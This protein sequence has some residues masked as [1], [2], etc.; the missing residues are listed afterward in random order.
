M[1]LLDECIRLKVRLVDYEKIEENGERKVAFGNWAGVAGAINAL[2]MMGKRMLS[3][4]HNTPLTTVNDAGGY[5]TS[6][7]AAVAIQRAGDEVRRGA[8]AKTMDPLTFVITGSGR[9]SQGAQ[10][11][12][13]V[14]VC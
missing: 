3:L 8:L 12:L 13:N 10:Q 14:M 1:A 11:I 6:A 2:H 5:F 7:E 4:G 9:V